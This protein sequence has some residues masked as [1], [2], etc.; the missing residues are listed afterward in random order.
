MQSEAQYRQHL[1]RLK[2]D[3]ARQIGVP[4]QPGYNGNLPSRDAGAVGGRIGGPIGGNM[5][6]RMIAMA[7][8]HM[9]Q[10]GSLS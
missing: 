7:E 5:V 3:V 4:L 1:D 10:R 8:Q 2:Y 6:R 9:A